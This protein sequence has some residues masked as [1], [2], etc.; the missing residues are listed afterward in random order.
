MDI[1]N[2]RVDICLS[3]AAIIDPFW[4]RLGRLQT[5]NDNSSPSLA[6]A[7]DVVFSLPTV[8]NVSGQD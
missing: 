8:T 3:Q 2:I 6:N 5:F 1:E 7:L 4:F